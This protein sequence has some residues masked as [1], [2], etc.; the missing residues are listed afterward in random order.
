M[1]CPVAKLD[2]PGN[3]HLEVKIDDFIIE[4]FV[5]IQGADVID[6]D[7]YLVGIHQDLSTT[8]QS[9]PDDLVHFWCQ[10]RKLVLVILVL[11]LICVWT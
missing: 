4:P 3:D 5:A 8:G 10:V 6:S 9:L 1:D 7:L 11:I 2:R